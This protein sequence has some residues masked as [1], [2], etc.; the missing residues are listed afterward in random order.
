MLLKCYKLQH[1]CHIFF[2]TKLQ[3]W[4]FLSPYKFQVQFFSWIFHYYCNVGS[5]EIWSLIWT[6]IFY[7]D[8]YFVTIQ[9][10]DTD[11]TSTKQCEA[12]TNVAIRV[13]RLKRDGGRTKQDRLRDNII[14]VL[15]CKYS[16]GI[17]LDYSNIVYGRYYLTCM[18]AEKD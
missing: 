12:I 16:T 5:I 2:N 6:W 13:M 17:I 18:L 3:H 8:R 11:A 4:T 7:T 10:V 9:T 14:P 1:K 15:Y